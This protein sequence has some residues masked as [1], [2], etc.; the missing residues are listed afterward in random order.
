MS[1]SPR[2]PW[3]QRLDALL[4]GVL[5]AAAVL[6]AFWMFVVERHFFSPLTVAPLILVNFAI[7]WYFFVGAQPWVE[8]PRRWWAWLGIVV[9]FVLVAG[10]AAVA[11]VLLAPPL[12]GLFRLAGR[13]IKPERLPARWWGPRHQVAILVLLFGVV[14]PLLNRAYLLRG[15]FFT[16]GR[17]EPPV[18]MENPL[19]DINADTFRGPLVPKERSTRPRLLFIGDS[20]TWGLPYRFEESYPFLV[21]AA[22]GAEVVNTAMPSQSM[23]QIERK[24]DG[25]LAWKPDV[26]LVMVGLQFARSVEHRRRIEAFKRPLLDLRVEWVFLPPFVADLIQ[27]GPYDHFRSMLFG[28]ENNGDRAANLAVFRDALERFSA[29][30]AASGRRVVFLEYPALVLDPE[31]R[32]MLADAARRHGF[33]WLPLAYLVPNEDEYAFNDKIHPMKEGH[34]RIAEAIVRHLT[35]ARDDTHPPP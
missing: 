34:R 10:L 26:V 24:L 7:T 6:H 1:P 23:V 21:G 4:F 25:Y 31:V 35:A 12:Y 9:A 19:Y 18:M 29:R 22:L 17:R 16:L 27:V 33:G 13:A 28:Q 2:S 32:S 8:R 20:T 14:G 5:A 15:V 30:A 11:V 3:L